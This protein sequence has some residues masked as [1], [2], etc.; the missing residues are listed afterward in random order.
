MLF[1]FLFEFILSAVKALFTAA[2]CQN[3]PGKSFL[4]DME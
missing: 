2:I 3:E 4:P 1:P